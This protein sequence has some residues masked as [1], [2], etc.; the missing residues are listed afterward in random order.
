VLS[1]TKNIKKA[2]RRDRYGLQINPTCGKKKPNAMLRTMINSVKYLL[3]RALIHLK[4]PREVNI[5]F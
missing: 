2:S 4:L 5:A 1:A 3:I